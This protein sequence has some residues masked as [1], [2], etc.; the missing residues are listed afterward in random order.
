MRRE[1]FISVLSGCAIRRGYDPTELKPNQVA[2]IV[3]YIN[4]R[5]EEAW[6]RFPWPEWKKVEERYF[7]DPLSRTAT[8]NIGDEV[9]FQGEYYICIRAIGTSSDWDIQSELDKYVAYKQNNKTEI[10]DVLGVYKTNPRIS[11][12]RESIKYSLSDN[13]VQVPPDSPNKIWIEFH[14]PAPK[15]SSKYWDSTKHYEVGQ[16]TFDEPWNNPNGSGECYQCTSPNRNQQ[17]TNTSSFWKLIPFP[18]ILST[19]VQ[20]AVA[21]DLLREDEQIQKAD[22]EEAIADEKLENEYLKLTYKQNQYQ[23]FS[24]TL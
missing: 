2:Q 19:F 12:Y 18:K 4:E 13:G 15:F 3:E 6:F 17:P 16:L 23:R 11:L 20:R 7:R 1:E 8:Y 21:A 5:V 22:A 10:V 14:P 24:P 9:F